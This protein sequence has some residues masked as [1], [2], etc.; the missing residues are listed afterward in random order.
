MKTDNTLMEF[1]VHGGEGLGHDENKAPSNIWKV[2][3][4]SG[5]VV[6]Y[7]LYCNSRIEKQCFLWNQQ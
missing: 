7:F 6:G 5:Y 3:R 4:Y 1:H 2:L